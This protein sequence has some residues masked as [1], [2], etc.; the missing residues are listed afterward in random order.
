[1]RR[2][3]A[4]ILRV[5]LFLWILGILCCL[6]FVKNPFW[7][8]RAGP[9]QLPDLEEIYSE[10]TPYIK[11]E[12]ADLQYTGFYSVHEDE[13]MSYCFI[14][15]L[16]DH[17]YLTEMSAGTVHSLTSD[18]AEG[19]KNVSVFGQMRRDGQMLEKMAASEGTDTETFKEKYQLGS[20][21]I[22]QYG[23]GYTQMVVCY[24]LALLAGVMLFTGT[25][26]IKYTKQKNIRRAYEE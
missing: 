9:D 5:V 12:H 11:L 16:G 26:Q 25:V 21:V 24:I 20:I 1:M 18:V 19:L 7:I 10:K 2:A 15:T 17:S 3:L 22:Y 6:I 8:H 14:V 4:H 23:S 13:I